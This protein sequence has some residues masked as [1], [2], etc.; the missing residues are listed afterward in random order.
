MMVSAAH[1]APPAPGQAE[2]ANTELPL[3][4]GS[5]I[6]IVATSAKRDTNAANGV[7]GYITRYQLGIFL[8]FHSGYDRV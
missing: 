2:S 1:I 8:T 3:P 7:E 5:V 6:N 4:D